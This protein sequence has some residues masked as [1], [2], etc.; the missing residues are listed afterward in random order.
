M[1]ELHFEMEMVVE[2]NVVNGL[3]KMRMLEKTDGVV[4]VY[5]FLWR[6]E[7]YL[8]SLVFEG[9]MSPNLKVGRKTFCLIEHLIF[10]SLLQHYNQIH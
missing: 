4:Y 9:A 10:V 6:Q 7:M 1:E 3:M 5:D 2:M 8:N